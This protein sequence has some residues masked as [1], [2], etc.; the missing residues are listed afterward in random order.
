MVS[1]FGLLLIFISV[2]RVYMNY[3]DLFAAC[4]DAWNQLN[5]PRLQSI[6]HTEW[7]MRER[8]S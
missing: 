7:I 6:T 3:D 5:E 4:R 2:N 8:Q 1:A